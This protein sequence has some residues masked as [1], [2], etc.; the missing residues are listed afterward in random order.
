MKSVPEEKRGAR[1]SAGRHG[2]GFPPQT[3]RRTDA[4]SRAALH[5]RDEPFEAPDDRIPAKVLLD[6]LLPIASQRLAQTIVGDK[7]VQR[8]HELVAIRVVQA[9]IGTAAVF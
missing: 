7:Q 3:L 6:V 4:L 1:M 5:P 2:R 9:C 8:F